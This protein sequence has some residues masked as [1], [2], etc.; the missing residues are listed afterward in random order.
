MSRRRKR[1][2]EGVYEDAYG[3]AATVKVGKKQR[4]QRFPRGTSLEFLAAWRARARDDLLDIADDDAPPL[5]GTFAGDLEHYLKKIEA[6]AKYKSDRSHLRAWLPRVGPLLRRRI[7]ASHVTTAIAAWKAEETS[8]RTIRHRVRVL[9][10]LY[11][12]LD[13]RY[14][15]TPVIGVEL[16]K[17]EAPHPVAVPWTMV[18]AV[19]ESLKQGKAGE[20]AHGP[21]RTIAPVDYAHPEKGR[22]RFLV[23]ATTGQRPAQLMRALPTDVDLKRKLWYVRAAKGGLSTAL[24]L[25]SQMVNAWKAFIKADAWGPFDTTA[26]GKLLRR[27]GWSEEYK[28]YALRSTLAIDMILGGADLSDVQAALG[29]RRIQTT[30]TH[31][32]GL[33]LARM[34]RAL[35]RKKRAAL[36]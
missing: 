23:L 9:R 32:A 7:R 35:K 26:F 14:A 24:P 6:K 15:P 8:A 19:A 22:A 20:K 31:Y 12:G 4:E 27:H 36:G 10:E 17:P 11:H 13:G 16:P 34:R 3:I 18:R 33:Q 21:N 1:I 25:D 30:Q 5:P 2:A 28:P 29:H